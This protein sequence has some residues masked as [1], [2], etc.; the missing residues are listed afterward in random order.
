MNSVLARAAFISRRLG[1]AI[2][3]IFAIIV[4]NFF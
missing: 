4:L 3:V 2:V 1:K